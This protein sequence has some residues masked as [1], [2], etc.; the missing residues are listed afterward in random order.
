MGLP[1]KDGSGWRPDSRAEL[2][3]DIVLVFLVALMFGF[4]T[5]LDAQ[6]QYVATAPSDYFV[7]GPSDGIEFTSE[8]VELMN[9]VSS[10]SLGLD[11]VAAE[12]LYCGEVR[13]GVV[14]D[15]RLADYIEDST[16][17]SV[18]GRC[19]SPV[20]VW[21]HSQP[22]GSDELSEEDKSLESTGASYTCIQSSEIAVSPVTGELNGLTCWE[23]INYGE[24]FELVSVYGR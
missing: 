10:R 23:I 24:S 11:A 9:D 19:E 16:L 14:R 2:F 20:D 21:V 22:S 8:S 12:R 15:F 5:G 4:F 18:S 6:V 3:A 1:W 7:G 13:N 17:T